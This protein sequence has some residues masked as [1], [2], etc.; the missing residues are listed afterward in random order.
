MKRKAWE[1]HEEG[2]LTSTTTEVAGTHNTAIRR[3][4][5]L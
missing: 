4:Q 2:V 5:M 3:F 1:R